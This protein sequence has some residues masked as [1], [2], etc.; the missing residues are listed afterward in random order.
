MRM[1]FL[2]DSEQTSPPRRGLSCLRSVGVAIIPDHQVAG[3]SSDLVAIRAELDVPPDEEIKWKPPKGSVLASDPDRLRTLRQQMLDA[4]VQRNARTITVTVDHGSAYTT[5]KAAELGRDVLLPW[6]Y[7]RVSYHLDDNDDIGI[8][9]ADKP[10]GGHKEDTRWLAE[11]LRLTN[12]GTEYVK[13]DRIVLP[14]VTA[15]EQDHSEA[16]QTAHPEER[17]TAHPGE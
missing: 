2:D 15:A 5:W 8:V 11:T 12:D 4:A 16:R 9:I 1:I 14:I 13:S 10:G 3:Y 6:L 7:E 17:Q